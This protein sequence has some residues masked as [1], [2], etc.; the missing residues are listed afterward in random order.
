[1]TGFLV[2]SGGNGCVT[3]KVVSMVAM[4]VVSM[5]TVTAAGAGWMF[6]F[7]PAG[8]CI[9]EVVDVDVGLEVVG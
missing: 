6:P 4:I 5:F 3:R 9:C 1:M 8:V 7:P 2:F